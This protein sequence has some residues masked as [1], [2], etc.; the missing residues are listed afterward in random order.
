MRSAFALFL[1]C[2]LIAGCGADCDDPAGRALALA[3]T[4]VSEYLAR[5]PESAIEVFLYPECSM[6]MH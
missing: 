6:V 2:F 5:S 4:Y 1:A 3:D